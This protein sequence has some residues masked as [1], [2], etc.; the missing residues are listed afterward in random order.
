MKN[1]PL[2]YQILIALILGTVL[3]FLFN[4]GEQ[5]L[6]GLTLTVSPRDGGYTVVQQ[7]P[8]R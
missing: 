6:V 3:G 5:S 4:P 1:L 8:D 2:H 7:E